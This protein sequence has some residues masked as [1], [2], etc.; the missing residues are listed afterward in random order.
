MDFETKMYTESMDV[1]EHFMKPVKSM[2][3]VVLEQ[4]Y[5]NK[6]TEGLKPFS[7]LACTQGKRVYPINVRD[8]RLLPRR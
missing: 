7:L 5:L 6:M 3:G 8:R 4:A 1:L 2:P